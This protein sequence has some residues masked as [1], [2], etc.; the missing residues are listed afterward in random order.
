MDKSLEDNQ[1]L[2]K[3]HELFCFARE[4]AIVDNLNSAI[5]FMKGK[6]Y[7]RVEYCIQEALKVLNEIK[8]LKMEEKY[9]IFSIYLLPVDAT[10]IKNRKYYQSIKFVCT[11]LCQKMLV[12]F[13]YVLESSTLEEAREE[14]LSEKF[15]HLYEGHSVENTYVVRF[16]DES[17]YSVNKGKVVYSILK[18]QGEKK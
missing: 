18:E 4:F 3:S 6:S 17:I 13:Q 15:I 10:S 11:V 9:D 5:R 16:M 8:Q 2:K 1:H 12:I 14:V 7:D